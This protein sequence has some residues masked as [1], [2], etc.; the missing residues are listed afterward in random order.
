MKDSAD[1]IC[2]LS[3]APGRAGIALIRVSG[4]RSFD[5]Y[6]QVFR[7]REREIVPRHATLGA[8]VD[9]RSREKIDEAIGICYPAP[10]SY[11]G[12]D[13]VE[14]TIHG[15]PVLAGAVLDCLCGSGARLADPGEFTLRAFLH[16]RIDLTQAEAV[17]DIIDASTLYQARIAARQQSGELSRQLQPLK[18]MLTDIIVDLESAVEFV[19]EDLGARSRDVIGRSLT[20][21]REILSRWIFS[22]RKGRIIREGFSLAVIGRPNVGKSSLF[23]GILEQDRSIVTD[24]PGTTRD[25]VSETASLGGIPVRLL[26]TAGIHASEDSIERLGID[27]T[28]QAIA[29]A[30][31]VL[32][33]IDGSRER[34][35]EDNALK[36]QLRNAPCILV[37]NKSDLASQW[38]EPEMEAFASG[39]PLLHVSAKTGSGISGLREAVIAHVLGSPDFR[40]EEIVVTNLRHCHCLEEAGA[41]LD[42]AVH[43]LREGLS[44]EFVLLDL[45]EA[46]RSLGMLTGEVGVEDLLDEIFSRFCVGK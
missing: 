20:E 35:P 22:F 2:A 11:T 45:H 33:V 6:R 10:A 25:L 36:E 5:V 41:H 1:T 23:N 19:E 13:L 44:E 46:L 32:F 16:G 42:K 28:M 24:R 4:D 7:A 9:P 43:S 38:P 12:E 14:F 31:A 37:M 29:D 34:S 15:S 3:T 26:D 39:W 40:Q 17:R 8:I 21:A 18:K 30:D 27:R